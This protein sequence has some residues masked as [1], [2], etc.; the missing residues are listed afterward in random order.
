MTLTAIYFYQAL[1]VLFSSLNHFSSCQRENTNKWRR[2]EMHPNPSPSLRADTPIRNVMSIQPSI[3]QQ[4]PC[5][6]L[7]NSCLSGCPIH[8]NF[9]P[10]FHYNNE[11]KKKNTPLL[12][13][14][15][16]HEL[17]YRGF[18]NS[19]TGAT[20]RHAPWQDW[21]PN[22]PRSPHWWQDL[23][24]PDWWILL[25]ALQSWLLQKM[26]SR[27]MPCSQVWTLSSLL[28]WQSRINTQSK[29]FSPWGILLLLSAKDPETEGWT[30]CCHL[31][32]KKRQDCQTR[33]GSKGESEQSQTPSPCTVQLHSNTVGSSGNLE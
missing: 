24:I 29:S 14:G 13:G 5:E 21:W 18:D 8:S 16:R 22:N 7:L 10:Q 23:R 25:F 11:K 2:K 12:N 17:W 31:K 26:H 27:P 28:V 1:Y 30:T 6:L 15:V 9:C 3:C 4:V 20:V 32:K 33:W 19:I